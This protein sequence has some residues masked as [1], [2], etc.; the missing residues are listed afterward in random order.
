MSKNSYGS[1]GI[2]RG[3]F[4]MKFFDIRKDIVEKER[5]KINEFNKK[6][7]DSSI[8]QEIYDHINTLERR[9]KELE[10]K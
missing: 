3:K 5:E 10:K 4:K 2:F 6:L 9:I 1:T 8:I 7:Y